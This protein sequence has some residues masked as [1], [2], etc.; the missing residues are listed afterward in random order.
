MWYKYLIFIILILIFIILFMPIN[1]Y[2]RYQ[3][4]WSCR[5]RV[6]GFEFEFDTSGSNSKKSKSSNSKFNDVTKN[7]K[8]KGFISSLKYIVSVTFL[9]VKTARAFLRRI[10]IK[11]LNLHVF[12]SGED[13]YETAI[14]YGQASAV[15]Y[16]SINYLKEILRIKKLNLMVEPDFKSLKSK[17][18]F[19][20][21]FKVNIFNLLVV[22]I[23][24]IKNYIFLESKYKK[25]R[26]SY[27]QQN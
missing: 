16:P 18:L 19:E 14:K 22:I 6:L 4:K 21:G 26:I 15:I 8:S 3:Q 9:T 2:I 24:F 13:A 11:Y 7:L 23:K 12:I 25:G 5:V 1:F 17:I 20:T 10:K 27:E